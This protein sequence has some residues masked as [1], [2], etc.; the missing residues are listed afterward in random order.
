MQAKAER[1][2][3][4]AIQAQGAKEQA[5]KDQQ[6]ARAK[7]EAEARDRE[8]A[9]QLARQRAEAEAEDQAEVDKQ[10]SA[11]KPDL[12]DA[13]ARLTAEN[14]FWDELSKQLASS[15][16]SLR[17]TIRA[18]L[19]SANLDGERCQELLSTQRRRRQTVRPE[20]K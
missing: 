7:A 12:D 4:R 17:S 3:Q 9:L 10:I 14:G 11:L 5:V 8:K 2:R 18:A 15:G 13:I 6:Q 1:S 19:N 20:A 16:Q